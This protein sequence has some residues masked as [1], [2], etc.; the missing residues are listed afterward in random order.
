MINAST[1][2][3]PPMLSPVRNVDKTVKL[4]LSCGANVPQYIYDDIYD[5]VTKR[6]PFLMHGIDYS[7]KQICGPTFWRKYKFDGY[8]AAGMSMHEM[9]KQHRVPFI[10]A[11][12]AHEY[13]K[14][15]FL[16]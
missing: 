7:L 2:K 3:A 14:K 15:Y 5:Q 6:A 9:V 12:T 10:V 16:K 4:T 8:S 11:E 13:P 1:L